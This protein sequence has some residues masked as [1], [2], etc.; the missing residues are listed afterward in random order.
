MDAFESIVAIYLDSLGYWVKQSVKVE[1]SKEEN[2]Y[3]YNAYP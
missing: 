1:I 2:R 3:L